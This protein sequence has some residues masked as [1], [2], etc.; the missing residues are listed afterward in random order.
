MELIRNV[1]FML[2]ERN[3]QSW[4]DAINGRD[5]IFL[6]LQLPEGTA[7]PIVVPRVTDKTGLLERIDGLNERF[8]STI[9]ISLSKLFARLR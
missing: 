5:D 1:L 3:L 9:I 6:V 4:R 7:S 8:V 2:K